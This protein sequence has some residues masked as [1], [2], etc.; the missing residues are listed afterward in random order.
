M[1]W[2][3]SMMVVA[4]LADEPAFE[5]ASARLRALDYEGALVLFEG[6]LSK[7]R[8]DAERAT[9][10]VYAGAARALLGDT[11]AARL[12]FESALR[13]EPGVTVAFK[14]SPKVTEL[15]AEV[16]ARMEK[17]QVAAGTLPPR[18]GRAGAANGGAP[19][20]AVAPDA[21]QAP[22]TLNQAVGVPA[23]SAAVKVFPIGA[24]LASA[25]ALVGAG[26]FA[27]RTASAIAV[28]SG[29]ETSQRDVVARTA[30]ANTALALA[31]GLGA[32]GVVL[33]GVAVGSAVLERVP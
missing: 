11:A 16:Q 1:V 21:E 8:P 27:L 12:A 19:A 29:R 18:A 22:N 13:T 5:Q 17:A 20:G 14:T 24:G 30:D 25:A 28:A 15:F 3:L 26:V 6:L 32:A 7:D 31:V 23:P 10:L 4:A 2:L 9:L 33:G